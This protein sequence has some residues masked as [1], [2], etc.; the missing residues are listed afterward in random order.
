MQQIRQLVLAILYLVFTN[1]II[2]VETWWETVKL[3][4]SLGL[5]LS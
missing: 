5:A 1:R 4:L 3:Q 2:T